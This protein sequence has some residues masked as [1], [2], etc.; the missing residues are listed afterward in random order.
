MDP[1]IFE[2]WVM[3]TK[4]WVTETSYPNNLWVSQSDQSLLILS[5]HE[6][7]KTHFKSKCIY[8]DDT[9]VGKIAWSE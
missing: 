5:I 3:E 8:M 7:Q 1:T 6:E 2:L 4:N 9:I